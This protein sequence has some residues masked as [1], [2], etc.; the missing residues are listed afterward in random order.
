MLCRPLKLHPKKGWSFTL[1]LSFIPL[2]Q[3]PQNKKK[4]QTVSPQGDGYSFS[5]S[6]NLQ[7]CFFLSAPAEKKK[8]SSDF[9]PQ[10]LGFFS[11]KSKIPTFH[12][13]RQRGCILFF[14]KV[15]LASS[16]FFSIFFHKELL[17]PSC[18]PAA[19][20]IIF[21]LMSDG[22]LWM[23]GVCVCVFFFLCYCF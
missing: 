13:K 16:W 9:S 22:G 19:F 12:A 11:F 18:G 17:I 3:T 15:S 21:F 10:N 7:S 20:V 14:A 5:D 2:R 1:I 23:K 4:P 6:L 8:R